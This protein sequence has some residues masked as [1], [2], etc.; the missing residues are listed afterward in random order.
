MAG[1]PRL[2]IK[3]HGNPK[4]LSVHYNILSLHHTL[5]IQT[6]PPSLPLSLLFSQLIQI[7]QT[8]P[9]EVDHMHMLT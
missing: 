7:V 1:D 3:C 9:E 6:L 8:T 4:F 5:P 2:A